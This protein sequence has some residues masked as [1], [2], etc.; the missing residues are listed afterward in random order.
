MEEQYVSFETAKMLKR[1]GFD[2]PLYEFYVRTKTKEYIYVSDVKEN[3]NAYKWTEF[4]IP[5][6]VDC[7]SRPTQALAAKWLR[8]KHELHVLVEPYVS[9]MSAD[10]KPFWYYTICPVSSESYDA[11]DDI[12]G[13]T[14]YKSYEEAMEA[15]LQCALLLIIE[16]KNVGE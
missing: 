15:G 2:V 13:I 8:E 5:D 3:H 6:F 12:L 4:D 9:R 14:R 11:D 16:K 10:G 1:A 7:C